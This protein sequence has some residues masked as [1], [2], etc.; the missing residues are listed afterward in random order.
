MELLSYFVENV[1]EKSPYFQFKE[2]IELGWFDFLENSY[3]P[4]N[5]LHVVHPKK[6]Y[7]NLKIYVN[8]Q[9]HMVQN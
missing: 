3:I 2:E 8:Q 5:K 9:I 4:Y 7:E 1:D 6:L